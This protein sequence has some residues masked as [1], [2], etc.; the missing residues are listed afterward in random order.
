VIFRRYSSVAYT[1][2][3]EKISRVN[4]DLQETV[5]GLRVAQAHT[6]ETR[7]AEEFA[8][9][10]DS[11]R[12]TRL[13]AQRYI[14]TFFPFVT[15]L[16]E[17]AQ[18]A[19]LGVGAVWVAGGSLSAGTLVAF[20]L[21]MGQFFAPVQQ[22]SNVFDGYQQAKVG[23]HRIGALLRTPSSVVEAT[24]PVAVPK[25]LDG[26]VAMRDVSF[27]YAGTERPALCGVRASIA[28]GETISLVGETGAGKST[29]VKLLARFYDPSAGRL[30]VDG[31]E[32]SDYRLADYRHHLGVVPQEAH[33][34]AGTVADNIRYG[35]PDAGDA[36]VE[37]AARSVGA[38]AMVA[39]LS[40]GFSQPV[41][42]RGQGLSAGQRQLVALD[43]AELVDPDVLLLD[44]ATAALDPATEAAVLAASERLAAPRTTFL[45]AHRLATASRADRILVLDAGRVVEEGSHAELLTRGGRYAALW[46]QGAAATA[47]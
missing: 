43:R 35:R 42:E 23:L 29:V 15:F 37:A 5:S 16:S 21:Y 28:P 22:L 46:E 2:A 17:T 14:A 9:L 13:R 24:E 30:T 34:F 19:V 47:A 39:G 7:S 4:A 36:E 8:A 38:L 20:L 26:R 40:Q 31:V 41:G 33:L 44:E 27:T 11:Y 18:A 1:E 12:R 32:L 25:T 10:S 6:R 45:V 3:R